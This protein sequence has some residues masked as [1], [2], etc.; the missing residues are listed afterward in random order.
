MKIKNQI[1]LLITGI[2]ILPTLCMVLFPIYTYYN[3][4]RRFLMKGY[5]EI[6]KI[7]E[8][9]LSESDWNQIQ[10]YIEKIPPEV[11]IM[12][13]FNSK[14]ILSTI[15]EIK[16]GSTHNP[17]ELF[18]FVQ[19]TNSSYDYQFQSFFL[20]EQAKKEARDASHK[21]KGLIISRFDA[22]EKSS[23]KRIP[24]FMMH[25]FFVVLVFEALSITVIILIAK[26][27][28]NS[29]EIIQKATQKIA[30]GELDTKLEISGRRNSNEILQLTEDLERM[31]KALKENLERRSRF[32]MGISHDLRTPV[33]LI[34]G[35]SE[36]VSDG[37]VNSIDDIKKSVSI[38]NTKAGQ[39][40][41]MIND[42]INYVKMDNIEW[43]KTLRPVELK[44]FLKDFAAN[45]ECAAELYK[46][47]ISSSIEIEEQQILMDKNLFTRALE[48]I[49]GN[50]LRYT[51]DGDSIS[52]EAKKNSFGKTE[53]SIS[54]TGVGIPEEDLEKVFELF[55]RASNSRRENGMGIGLSV[56]KSIIDSHGW[57]I[58][59]KSRPNKGT[60]FTITLN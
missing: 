60:T 1:S 7:N 35:Y 52:L 9:N 45:M 16:T 5:R 21:N 57:S 13:F 51:N 36:A 28:S 25:I 4:P 15:P 14:I 31:R 20:E 19:T 42:L 55:F 23:L 58:N 38:I 26:S 59:V 3:S 44:A 40:E 50:A 18:D 39:L 33:A 22:K 30:N 49:Y 53:I 12:I 41:S 43:K 2:L 6:R 56:V 47:K 48:N 27:V 11:Q 32:I 24:K 37:I 46:R 29:I 34:K 8:A 17:K 54:D 10:N